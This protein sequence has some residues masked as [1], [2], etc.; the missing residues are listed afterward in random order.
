M[1]SL[2]VGSALEQRGAKLQPDGQCRK[3]GWRAWN[4][5][6]PGAGLGAVQTGREEAFGIGVGALVHDG[7][8]AARFD[9]TAGIHHGEPVADL[10]GSADIM[11]DENDRHAE[12]A[13]QLA[14]QQ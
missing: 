3:I 5:H 2:Q 9:K 4:R 10:N 12:L 7:A 11:G 14:Q 1:R 8:R 6:Q 13:L